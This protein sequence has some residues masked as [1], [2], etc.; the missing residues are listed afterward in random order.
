MRA[1]LETGFMKEALNQAC[2]I[3]DLSAN[4]AFSAGEN[5]IFVRIGGR[6]D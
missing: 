4:S 5:Y 3:N 1:H 6:D 2:F